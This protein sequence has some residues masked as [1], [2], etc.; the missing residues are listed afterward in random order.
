MKNVIVAPLNW[1]LGHASRCVPIIEL[2]IE[3]KFTPV[4]ASDG[5]ALE[6]LRKEFPDV[7]YLELPSYNI[8][9]GKNLKWS[10][11]R[12]I[13]SIRAAAKKERKILQQYLAN[14][15]VV[16]LISDNRFGIYSKQIPSAYITHQINVLSGIL[17]PITSF[18]HQ[19]IIKK[20]HECWIPDNPNSLLSGKL[21]MS[22]R[23][24][25]QKYIGILSRFEKKELEKEIDIL[26]VLSGPE[27][28]RTYLE[29][30]MTSTFQNTK[31][32]VWLVRGIVEGKQIIKEVGNLKIVNFMLSEELEKTL[33][34]SRRVICRSG[35]S[36]VMDLITLNKK[37]LLIPTKGQNEQEYL[38]KYLKEKGYFSFVKE[39]DFTHESL[40]TMD[41]F[42]YQYQK[43]VF[44]TE[45]FRLFESK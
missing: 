42:D 4:L 41:D 10:L 18:F 24:L 9:Y 1:G 3:N 29:Q 12:K 15:P 7:E 26:I 5:K 38:A 44:N 16:G 40:E 36:S 23:K 30:K 2:L 28:N 39:E 35:Y 20:F 37:A 45:L 6:F 31:K 27:P 43:T 8:S 17:T 34:Q 33:N 19:R 14:H 21:S 25:N 11:F 22:N 13:F 32:N